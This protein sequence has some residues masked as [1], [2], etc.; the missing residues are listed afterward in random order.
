MNQCS[1]PIFVDSLSDHTWR[2]PICC[3]N[4]WFLI[5]VHLWTGFVPTSILWR[6]KHFQHRV[7]LQ[8]VHLLVLSLFAII[9]FRP[10]LIQ[11]Q[12]NGELV[13]EIDGGPQNN[14]STVYVHLAKMTNGEETANSL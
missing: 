4:K 3:Q 11:Q 7:V 8:F 13:L 1:F 9:I 2:V 5:F 14:Q 6:L 12:A 10:E